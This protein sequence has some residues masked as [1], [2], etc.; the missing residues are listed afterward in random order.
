VSFRSP[1]TALQVTAALAAGS[2]VDLVTG[3]AVVTDKATVANA[4]LIQEIGVAH[5]AAKEYP[6]AAPATYYV[7]DFDNVQVAFNPAAGTGDWAVQFVW[8]TDATRS[9][10]IGVSSISV[11]AAT[12][13]YDSIPVQ[14]PYLSIQVLASL[15]GAG[16]TASFAVA[17]RKG[18]SGMVGANGDGFVL[19]T[20]ATALGAG[21][22]TGI[23]TGSLIRGG[24]AVLSVASTQTSWLVNL[25][26][27]P[28]TGFSRL[29]VSLSSTTEYGRAVSVILPLMS[30]AVQSANLAGVA[31]DLSVTIMASTRT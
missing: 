9:L 12:P 23:I 3:A 10:I 7:G 25:F 21:A 19:Y 6:G 24:P 2:A 17:K 29:I 27:L 1:A 28:S 4:L 13:F 30:I 18:A 22:A 16:Q 31:A 26:A 15:Y 5:L 11:T 8:Y 14:G 20:K